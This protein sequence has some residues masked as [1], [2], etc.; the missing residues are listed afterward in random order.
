M[1]CAVHTVSVIT[2]AWQPDDQQL[3]ELWGSLATQVLPTG[4][5]LEWCVQEDGED[6]TMPEWLA[7]VDPVGIHI[8]YRESG[9]RL[10]AA[11]TRNLALARSSGDLIVTLD[12]HDRLLPEAVSTIVT[13]LERTPSVGWLSTGACAPGPNGLVPLPRGLRGGVAKGSARR[14]W[15]ALGTAPVPAQSVSYRAEVLWAAGGW[16]ALPSHSQLGAFL[17]ASD[18][19]TGLVVAADTHLVAEPHN[20]VNAQ[21]AAVTAYLRRRG[22]SDPRGT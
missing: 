19:A 2:A 11:T 18:M 7:T 21:M 9:E 1:L 15:Q 10:G 20:V 4:W 6:A 17:V 14:H 16:P 22:A 13:A 12:Q 3:S 5:R 8:L